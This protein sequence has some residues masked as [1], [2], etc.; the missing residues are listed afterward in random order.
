[1]LSAQLRV[2]LDVRCHVHRLLQLDVIM[3]LRVFALNK[4]EKKRKKENR[5]SQNVSNYSV[6]ATVFPAGSLRLYC[7]RTVYKVT[8]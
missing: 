7:V 2:Q 8:R 4:K 1:M 3:L 5:F 6:L